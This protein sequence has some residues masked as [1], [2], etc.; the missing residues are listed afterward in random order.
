MSNKV[1]FADLRSRSNLENKG[2]KIV[3]LF[4]KA[5]FKELFTP[6]DLVA[7]KVHFG[8]RGNDS[9]VSPVMIRY[10]VDKIKENGA[11]MFVTDTNTLYYGSRHNA[12]SHLE[13]AILNGFDYSV[14]GAPLIIADGLTSEN[15][16]IVEINQK[17]FKKVK[18]AGDLAKSTS[19][20]VVSHFKGHGLS[21][22][23]GALKNL[24][25]G[26]ATIA[27]KLDQHKCAKPIIKD[28]C[29][30]CAICFDSC[31]TD[32]IIMKSV[33]NGLIASIEYGSCVA[34]MNCMDSCENEAI[35]VDW[36]NDIPLFVERMMEY[37]Y[38][39][40]NGKENKIAYFN[41]LVNITPDCDC[42]PWS[43]APMVPDIG[44]LASNDPV[45]IDTASYDLVNS[46][47]GFKNS[48]L[49]KNFK[50]GEDKFK[51]VWDGVDGTKQLEYA[52]KMGMGTREYELIR[53]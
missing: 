50:K 1:Y 34:C 11:K 53:L 18:I 14:V 36:K 33:D 8:E 52:E 13:T 29:N 38:G 6:E 23:G 48:L 35:D 32:A 49:D 5:G 15:E 12:V 31:P 46:Q 9:Y 22:F 17:H 43:D 2:N 42:V 19:M 3:N 47:K 4:D 7:V 21:G 37:A 44:I 27:G 26:C 20:V 10:L 45:A 25:M 24:A 30:G 16:E 28:N 41:F 51:G 39:A 40:L